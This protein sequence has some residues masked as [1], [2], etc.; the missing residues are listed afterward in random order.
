MNALK[1]SVAVPAAV[2]NPSRRTWLLAALAC[3]LP[4]AWAMPSPLTVDVWKS[5]ACGC[6]KDWVATLTRAGFRVQLHETGNADK[7]R[8]LGIPD[9]LGSCHTAQVGG[10]ALEG[11]VPVTEIQRLLREKPAAI[12][13][14]VPGMPVGSPGM[15]GPAYGGRHM[16]FDVLLVQGGGK[17]Q[18]YR[19]YGVKP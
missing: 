19:S 1:Q 2:L 15:D 6:C 10:Y 9:S 8:Q 14:A 13:L 16:P 4:V 7:R 17:V 11:H 18:V 3:S 12:G 5:P